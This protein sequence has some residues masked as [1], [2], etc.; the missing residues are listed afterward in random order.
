M[1]REAHV[2]TL[3][4]PRNSPASSHA[5]G[6]PG[7]TQ[8]AL[9]GHC[10]LEVLSAAQTWPR[11]CPSFLSGRMVEGDCPWSC[12]TLVHLALTLGGGATEVAV[13]GRLAEDQAAQGCSL[14]AAFVSD[15]QER[16][17]GEW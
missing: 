14:S 11:S 7:D 1:T 3:L 16:G 15:Q 17:G 6:T 10:L 13:L 5:A 8:G 2:H 12:G 4:G 9:A